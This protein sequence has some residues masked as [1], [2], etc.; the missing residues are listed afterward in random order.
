MGIL[1]QDLQR[2]LSDTLLFANVP[3]VYEKI[4][5]HVGKQTKVIFDLITLE[6][7]W[8]NTSIQDK[9]VS[10]AGCRKHMST[11]R[12]KRIASLRPNS[13]R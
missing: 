12:H 3:P 7:N 1:F 9:T 5:K 11:C 8:L 10:G 6:R 4:D 2:S 13:I